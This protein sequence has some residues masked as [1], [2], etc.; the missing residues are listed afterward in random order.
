[1]VSARFFLDTYFVYQGWK[2]TE[3][4]SPFG[5]D[6][7]GEAMEYGFPSWWTANIKVG[8]ELG[9]YVDFMLAVKN[10]FNQFYKPYAAGVS[11]AGRNFIITARFTL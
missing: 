1:M 11:S 7:E 5:E 9:K 10:I 4:F 2:Y 8:F 3:D 6:N